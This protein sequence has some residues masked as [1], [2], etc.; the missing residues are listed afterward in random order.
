MHLET[1]IHQGSFML[2]ASKKHDPYDFK[3]CPLK[4]LGLVT[5]F[6]LLISQ[7]RSQ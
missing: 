4:G 2:I 5:S 1:Q 3:R 7:L 6:I